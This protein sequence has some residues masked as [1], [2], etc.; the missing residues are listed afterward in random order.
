M[1]LLV[2]FREIRG[3]NDVKSVPSVGLFHCNTGTLF[4]PEM[5]HWI[6]PQKKKI[7]SVNYKYLQVLHS[8]IGQCKHLNIWW[9][10]TEVLYLGLCSV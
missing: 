6:Y 4:Y 3:Y 2:C 10:I 1:K 9:L 7:S 8:W 5:K